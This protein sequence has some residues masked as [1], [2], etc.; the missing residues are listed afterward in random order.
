MKQTRLNMNM[1]TSS[2]PPLD[3]ADG[4]RVHDELLSGRI[5]RGG[6]LQASE[7]RA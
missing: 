4:G 2:R 5:E 6:G 7:V 1:L 3:G